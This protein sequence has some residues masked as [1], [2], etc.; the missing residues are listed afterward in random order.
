MN[1]NNA[2]SVDSWFTGGGDGTTTAKFPT[3]GTTVEGTI[4]GEPTI[5]QQTTFGSNEPATWPNGEPK[6]QLI[7]ELETSEGP[8]KLYVKGKNLETAVKSAAPSGVASGGHLSVSYVA[9]ASAEAGRFPAKVYTATYT[10]LGDQGNLSTPDS[11]DQAAA[12]KAAGL[13]PF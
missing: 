8:K 5:T 13:S 10:P 3:V 1:D 7:V 9:D 2:P 4:V 6:W 12:M 11:A